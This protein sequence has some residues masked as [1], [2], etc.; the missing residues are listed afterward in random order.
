MIAKRFETPQE[1]YRQRQRRYADV[2]NDN[3]SQG[4]TQSQS[5]TQ[6]QDQSLPCAQQ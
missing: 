5:Q 1:Y 2:V 6:S 3:A 4:S